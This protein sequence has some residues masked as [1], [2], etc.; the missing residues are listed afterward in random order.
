[1]AD[2]LLFLVYWDSP[3]K[4]G[5]DLYPSFRTAYENY[6]Q[7]CKVQPP[8]NMKQQ[9]NLVRGLATKENYGRHEL[10]QQPDFIR[11]GTL[12]PHQLD[13]LK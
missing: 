4:K 5:S 1:M 6:L 12:M 10:R 3:P 7:A 11:G 13:G 8:V 2:I 9:V